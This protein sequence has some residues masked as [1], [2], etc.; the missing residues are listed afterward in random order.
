MVDFSE[1][2]GAVGSVCGG[3]GSEEVDGVVAEAA[4]GLQGKGDE[5]WVWVAEAFVVFGFEGGIE[6]FGEDVS[7]RV[8]GGV[9]WY[10]IDYGGVDV[11]SGGFI[12]GD[13]VESC[14]FGSFDSC[15]WVGGGAVEFGNMDFELGVVAVGVD[16][17]GEGTFDLVMAVDAGFAAAA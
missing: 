17:V 4:V 12:S 8:V 5:V 7:G 14:G 11:S 9:L 2:G 6:S 16:P 15:L 10:G 13:D 1:G 3:D